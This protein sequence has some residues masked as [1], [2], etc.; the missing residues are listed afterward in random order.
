MP[1]LASGRLMIGLLL[2]SLSLGLSNF[3]AAIGIGLSGVSARRRLTTGL[4]FAFFEATMPILGLLIGRSVAGWLDATDYFI[5][6]ILLVGTG[7]YVIWK[8]RR[9]TGDARNGEKREQLGLGHLFV[10]T[11]ALSLYSLVVGFALSFSH[12]AIIIAAGLIAA[13]SVSMAL[14]GLELGQRLGAP[15]EAW[16]EEFGGAVLIVVGFAVGVGLL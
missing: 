14:V 3:A 9:S 15:F 4:A 7:T 1:Q 13:V 8:G 5:G 2:V 12:V 10:T 16:T 6:A 11:F